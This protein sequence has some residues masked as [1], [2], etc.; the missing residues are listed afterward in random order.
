MQIQ[1]RKRQVIEMHE[2]VQVGKI[3]SKKQFAISVK[4]LQVVTKKEYIQ[5]SNTNQTRVLAKIQ[6][7]RLSG[8]DRLMT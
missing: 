7:G 1:L 4:R 2:K 8:R 5:V 6:K 3:G